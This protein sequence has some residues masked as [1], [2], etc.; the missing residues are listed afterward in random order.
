M[1][2]CFRLLSELYSLLSYPIT[3]LCSSIASFPSP[4]GVIFSLMIKVTRDTF[5]SLISVS[6][7]SRSYILSYNKKCNIQTF[8]RVL[9]FPSPLGVIFSLIDYKQ[10]YNR[11]VVDKIV[12]VSSRSYILSYKLMNLLNNCEENFMFPSPLGFIFSLMWE[13]LGW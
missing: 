2:Q 12:S 7:S 11:T 8:E 4:L 1:K 6:V 13:F 3:S 5:Y 9:K 10:Q